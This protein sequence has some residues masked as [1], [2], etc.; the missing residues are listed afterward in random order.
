MSQ[1]QLRDTNNQPLPLK[2]L[3][4]LSCVILLNAC[5]SAP[6]RP[7]PAEPV[8]SGIGA[9][10]ITVTPPMDGITI[11]VGPT[12]CVTN[13]AGVA[14]C[15]PVPVGEYTLVFDGLSA[16]VVPA[17]GH[18]Q[19]TVR[20]A[21]ND[22]AEVVAPFTRL[23]PRR[24]GLVRRA[25]RAVS[26]DGGLFHPLG[27]TFFWAVWGEQADRDRMLKNA[28]ALSGHDY[29]RILGEVKWNADPA[30]GWPGL[31]IDPCASDYEQV[32]GATIDDLY[33]VAGL[34]SEITLIGGGTSCDP[35]TIA[36]KVANVINAGR[37][38]KIM[39]LEASNESYDNGPDTPTLVQM[40]RY[41][42]ATTTVQLVALSSPFDHP[43][44]EALVA[45]SQ[46]AGATLFTIHTERDGGN[47]KW[48]QV[49][50]GY[51][52][53]ELSPF[54]VDSNEPPGPHS[55][56]DTNDSPL[57]LA[58]M[59]ALSVICG[60][61][62][63]VFHVGDMV[64]GR[65][66]PAHN[67][68]PNIWQVPNYAAM[69][70][71]VRGIDALLPAGVENWHLTN[72]HGSSQRIGPHPL[73]ADGIWSDGDDHGVDRAYG[74]VNGS[75]FVEVLTGVKRFV[76]LRPLQA[77]HATAYDPETLEVKGEVELGAADIWNLP[78]RDD[79]M[80]AYIVR[81]TFK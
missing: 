17:E 50:Q 62:M 15:V 57:Q 4:L 55:S 23:V 10:G 41:L 22:N 20:V 47:L 18:E 68:Q 45:A 59:R 38:N 30:T 3:A 70:A 21:A 37:V 65:V 63:W 9:V 8:P 12:S 71:A 26:D 67:R 76:N 19:I 2:R 6:I 81:G 24:S 64:M 32:L 61:S 72:Q 7:V 80:T 46:D 40:V 36:R 69:F 5:A 79:T 66:D 54:V 42:R 52:A 58:T 34:R 78:G 25:G 16:D 49:R 56:I 29:A 75:E 1:I 27:A 53:G 35:M 60:G 33:D 39:A 74:A 48:R 43:G 44:Q 13:G 51:G 14:Y 73:L 77:M 28:K 31:T 11:H